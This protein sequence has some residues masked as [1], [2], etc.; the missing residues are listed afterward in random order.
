VNSVCDDES[1][2]RIAA[3]KDTEMG[4]TAKTAFDELIAEIDGGMMNTELSREMRGMVNA[5]EERCRT[6]GKAKGEITVKLKFSAV[7]NGRVEI[8]CDASLKRPGVPKAKET[9]WIADGGALAVGDP[10]QNILPLRTPN[11]VKD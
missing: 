10:R 4:T 5:L 2:R 8:E 6:H 11:S 1:T 9:R 3:R 7:G